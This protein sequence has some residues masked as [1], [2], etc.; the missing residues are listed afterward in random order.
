VASMTAAGYLLG[1][2][3]W[4]KANFEKIVIG[5]ILVTTL[6]VLFKMFF[7]KKPATAETA[8][9]IKEPS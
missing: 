1:E 8:E 5:L 4:V 9:R 3:E 7:G 2:N 6:P